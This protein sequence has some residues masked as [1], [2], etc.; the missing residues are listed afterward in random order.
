M[1]YACASRE[2]VG[3]S[4]TDTIVIASAY[5]ASCNISMYLQL[6]IIVIDT[7]ATPVH[8]TYHGYVLTNTS[9]SS[10]VLGVHAVSEG[11]ILII[12]YIYMHQ[13]AMSKYAAAGTCIHYSLNNLHQQMWHR[14]NSS[15]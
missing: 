3:I 12:T 1:K 11:N 13:I 7:S 9:P 2:P 4:I 5:S 15:Q 14:V 6:Y 8:M 10:G